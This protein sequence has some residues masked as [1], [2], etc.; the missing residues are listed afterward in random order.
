MVPRANTL[1]FISFSPAARDQNGRAYTACYAPGR[2]YVIVLNL[3]N[4]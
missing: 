1:R 4:R 3:L 2:Q